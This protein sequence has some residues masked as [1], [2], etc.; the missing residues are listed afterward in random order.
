MAWFRQA[1]AWA[2]V[3]RAYGATF[4]YIF[5]SICFKHWQLHWTKWVLYV[6]Y[7]SHFG[8]IYKQT[9]FKF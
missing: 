8:Y 2:N 3:D 7:T 9:L 6:E 5:L 1:F 4:A